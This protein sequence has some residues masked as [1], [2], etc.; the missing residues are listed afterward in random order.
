MSKNRQQ[1]RQQISTSLSEP[2]A[3]FEQ[4]IADALND[5]GEFSANIDSAELGLIL[6]KVVYNLVSEQRLANVEVPTLHNISLMDARIDHGEAS[7]TC[8][9]HIHQPIIAFI[10]L[11]YSL[12]NDPRSRGTR[13]RLK[14]NRVEV[15]ESTRP[16]DMAAKVAL[17]VMRVESVVRHELSDPNGL[18]QRMLP[19]ALAQQGFT[20]VVQAVELEFNGDSSLRVYI[21]GTKD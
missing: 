17:K 7:I 20:G 9:I 13:L 14:N 2:I 3:A 6:R 16:L 18:I 8:E 4:R 12:E 15:H 10:R 1:L 19:D 5:D 21:A 11:K